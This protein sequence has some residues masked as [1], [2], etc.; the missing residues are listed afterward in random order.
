MKTA[1]FVVVALLAL[2]TNT[3]AQTPPVHTLSWDYPVVSTEVETYTHSVTLDNVAVPGTP[4][5]V[6]KPGVASQTTCS[7]TLPTLTTGV[8][9]VDVSATRGG[10]TRTTRLSGVNISNAPASPGTPR[11]TIQVTIVVP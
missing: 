2:T 7:L 10:I 8:H 6:V 9:T 4:A 3:Q 1:L 11:V 5:C